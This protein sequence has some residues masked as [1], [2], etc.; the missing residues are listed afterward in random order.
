MTQKLLI[1]LTILSL[2]CGTTSPVN[3]QL[4]KFNT[5]Y[6]TS[7]PSASSGYQERSFG[8]SA[9]V[10]WSKP[11]DATGITS[12]S[13]NRAV[14]TATLDANV[15]KGT[16]NGG[17]IYMPPNAAGKVAGAES[18]GLTSVT[19][20]TLSSD[21]LVTVPVG[22]TGFTATPLGVFPGWT[23]NAEFKQGDKP[24]TASGIG[25]FGD[26]K[27]SSQEG[28]QSNLSKAFIRINPGGVSA[29]PGNGNGTTVSFQVYSEKTSNTDDKT[30][31]YNEFGEALNNFIGSQ[32]LTQAVSKNF[33][34]SFDAMSSAGNGA[35]S[36]NYT[37]DEDE[38]VAGV[39]VTSG[40]FTTAGG[41]L[42][43]ALPITDALP[44]P[45]P[46]NYYIEMQKQDGEDAEVLS[47]SSVSSTGPSY[48]DKATTAGGTNSGVIT[49]VNPN[50]LSTAAGGALVKL[51]Y[52]VR[53]LL[54]SLIVEA[55]H[56]DRQQPL[57]LVS[58]QEVHFPP[59]IK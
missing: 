30:I 42:G 51:R 4:S 57:T 47:A 15:V 18:F 33:Q 40:G 5:L 31:E 3:A 1:R 11:A 37:L 16:L 2:F 34:F 46:P 10:P 49:F 55:P 35:R 13:T 45:A 23:Y 41:T 32:I 20:P 17:R 9:P 38:T 54:S 27:F 36:S 50:N 48:L 56:R 19:I 29:S 14:A 53:T 7:N 58:M 12:I 43:D 52:N 24:N 6:P 44:L 22:S 59:L 21:G 39:P 26:G 28:N 8:N 25:S